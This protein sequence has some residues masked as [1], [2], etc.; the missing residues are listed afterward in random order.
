MSIDKVSNTDPAGSNSTGFLVRRPG[1]RWLLGQCAA[2][3]LMAAASGG[4]VAAS[5]VASIAQTI[6]GQIS[7]YG[8]IGNIIDGQTPLV[9]PPS[10]FFLA[11]DGS[12]VLKNLRWSGWGTSVAQATGLWSASDCTPDCA[13][14]NLTTSP[15]TL[16]LSSPGSVLGHM[17][18]RCIKWTPAHPKRDAWG[19]PECIQ[20]QGNIY[21]YAPASTP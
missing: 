13:G 4:M 10:T 1:A 15:V 7:F 9:A 5:A 3:F 16:T 19:S 17:V 21:A 6:S 11:E 20:K 12:V 8:D 2:A 18:Y 14:G